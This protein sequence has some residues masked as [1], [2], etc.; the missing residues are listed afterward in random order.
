MASLGIG[1][2]AAWYLVQSGPEKKPH[3]GDEAHDHDHGKVHHQQNTE[4]EEEGQ[5]AE[6]AASPEAKGEPERAVARQEARAE[7]ANQTPSV[8]DKV[9]SFF[10]WVCL[11][12]VL[13]AMLVAGN[14]GL[15]VSSPRLS[16]GRALRRRPLGSRRVWIMRIRRIRLRR[17][18]N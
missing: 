2:P 10:R 11:G 15:T 14:A 5:Q 7:S 13:C 17:A 6:P 18:P 9:L 3:H 8:V 16:N 1:G 12:Y 4:E